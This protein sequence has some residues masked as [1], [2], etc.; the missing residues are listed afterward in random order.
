MINA[1]ATGPVTSVLISTF[2]TKETSYP[3]E[4]NIHT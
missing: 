3:G 4:K 1:T 2:G